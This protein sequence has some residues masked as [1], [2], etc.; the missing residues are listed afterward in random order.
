MQNKLQK[1]LII[2]DVHFPYHDKR[3]WN[4]MLKT[5]VAF[6]PDTIITLGDFVDFYS[7][8]SH[9][10]NPNRALKLD[11]EVTS[12]KAGLTQLEALG[13]KRKIFIAG[14]HCY[15]LDR[16]LEA[17]APELFNFVSTDKILDLKNRGWE[18]IPYKHDIRVGKVNFIHDV[19]TA[20][21]TS[22]FKCLDT[23]QH[24]IVTGHTHRMAYI[25]EGNAMGEHKV[26]AQFGW[27][28][29]LEAADYM[30][31]VN[32][33][34]NWALGFGVGYLE[35]K[36]GVVYLQPIPIVN[37]SCVL[38]GKLYSMKGKK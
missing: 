35:P 27:L 13:A 7:V 1:L 9:S 33:R 25:V 12:A 24:S 17:A 32:A 22:V 10:K 38:E 3:A 34:K 11:E 16:Y 30:H 20:G 18:Y 4:L 2:P 6:K 15:R 26:S 19:G 36:S 37:Y 31:A 5:A 29:D 21:R 14:N 23:Y 28:G 8:S